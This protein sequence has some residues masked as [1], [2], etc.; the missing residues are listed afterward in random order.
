MNKCW[1]GVRSGGNAFLGARLPCFENSISL[2]GMR[3]WAFR[4]AWERYRVCWDGRGRRSTPA[5]GIPFPP[6]SAGARSH[7]SKRD[8]VL[9]QCRLG[10]SPSQQTEY[11]SHPNPG[12]GKL[13]R[14]RQRAGQTALLA[15]VR[16]TDCAPGDSARDR[17]CFWRQRTSQTVHLATTTGCFGPFSVAGG[18]VCFPGCR[19]GHS[20]ARGLSHSDNT[21]SRHEKRAR[22][23]SRPPWVVLCRACRLT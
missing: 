12:A 8:T 20:L 3:K 22:P 14:R 1:S 16:G 23:K 2:V 19:Q 13:C 15:T 6:G 11:R 21:S 10:L 5:N 7:P 17:L 9:N 18:T 4:N